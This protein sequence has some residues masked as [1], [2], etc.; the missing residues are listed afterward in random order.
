MRQA[1][2][3]TIFIFAVFVVSLSLTHSVKCSVFYINLILVHGM[4]WITVWYVHCI[5]FNWLIYVRVTTMM[6]IW[7]VGH[8]L[9]STLTNGKGFTALSLPW[10]SPIQVLTGLDVT[11]L[12]WPSHRASIGR[13]LSNVLKYTVIR[14]LILSL[15]HVLYLSMCIVLKY[16]VKRVLYLSVCIVLKYSVIKVKY[17]SCIEVQC[18]ERRLLNVFL[19]LTFLLSLLNRRSDIVMPHRSGS[20]H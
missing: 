5:E 18:P 15:I 2:N 4:H 11:Y 1:C 19:K 17:V 12:Q 3:I 13:H 7:T 8:R 16:S 9:R 20:G 10:W 6:A 14:V